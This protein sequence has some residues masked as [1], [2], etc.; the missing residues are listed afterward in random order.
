MEVCAAHHLVFLLEVAL[1]VVMLHFDS[2]LQSEFLS[3]GTTWYY[4][5]HKALI[6]PVIRWLLS[7]Q[8]YICQKWSRLLNNR[9]PI[10]SCT[11]LIKIFLFTAFMIITTFPLEYLHAHFCFPEG[12]NLSF[13][14]MQNQGSRAA[15][16]ANGGHESV[17]TMAYPKYKFQLQ[18]PQA[19]QQACQT[20]QFPVRLRS[21]FKCFLCI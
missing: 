20:S 2:K 3:L 17:A 14:K 15:I 8:R 9:G 4:D 7:H 19:H 10:P 12:C 1:A 18:W 13:L 21:T 11:R 6:T 16:L 5:V